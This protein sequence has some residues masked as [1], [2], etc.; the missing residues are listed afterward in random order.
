MKL[1]DSAKVSAAYRI[2][3]KTKSKNRFFQLSPKRKMV[4]ERNL[5]LKEG[6]KAYNPV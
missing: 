2:C 3:Q 1:L 5:V 6:I 4:N